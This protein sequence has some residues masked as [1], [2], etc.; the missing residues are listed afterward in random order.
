VGI[1]PIGATLTGS[2]NG[3]YSLAVTPA[4]LT[5]AQ[6]P[7]LAMLVASTSNTTIG[8]SVTLNAQVVSTTAGGPT[9]SVTL[10]DGAGVLA[11]VPI[12]SAGLAAFS[13]TSLG[14]GMHSLSMVYAG[15]A[16]FLP[17]TSAIATVVVG[18]GPDFSIASVGA[19]S[20]SIPA[21]STATFHFSVSLQGSG[22]ASPIL[23][24]VQGVPVGATASLNPTSLPPGGAVTSFTLTIQTPL[25]AFD[26]QTRPFPGG[27]PDSSS[28]GIG[29]M[30]AV[31]LVPVIGFGR[32]KGSRALRLALKSG[33]CILFAS[34]ATGC[35]DRVN[36]ASEL[37]KATTYTITV[38]GT[39]TGPAG[40]ALQHS[41]NVTLEV[42]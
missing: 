31:F 40:N 36:T 11:V 3:N 34:L 33:F 19:G 29:V 17:S 23:L 35:G 1:Y 9:G 6:A 5:I 32:R 38:T 16:N 26:K 15:D 2:A 41:A 8:S 10:L 7:S 4:M 14:L 12:S 13:T 39:A 27:R 28:A 18:V 24:A 25:A 30:L 21:G 20:Q 22:L 42:L 37:T